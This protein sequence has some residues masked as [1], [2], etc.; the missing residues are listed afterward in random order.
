MNLVY[1][2]GGRGNE[3]KKVVLNKLKVLFSL[4]RKV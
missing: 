3:E 1:D 4:L 2:L